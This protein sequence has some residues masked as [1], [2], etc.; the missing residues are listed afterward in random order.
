MASHR[1]TQ[2][3]L[4]LGVFCW[5]AG[6]ATLAG[7]AESASCTREYPQYSQKIQLADLTVLETQR[8]DID[9]DGEKD[10]L[11]LVPESPQRRGLG[12]SVGASVRRVIVGEQAE[13]A[14]VELARAPEYDTGHDA[15]SFRTGDLNGDGLLDIVFWRRA[16]FSSTNPKPQVFDVFLAAA[17]G[18]YS[19]GPSLE[20][21]FSSTF[22]TGDFNGDGRDELAV[23][24][25]E[26]DQLFI[27]E[28]GDDATWTSTPAASIGAMWSLV[29]ADIDGDGDDD[30]LSGIR[31]PR[32]ILAWVEG[33]PISPLMSERSQF[34]PFDLDGSPLTP[35]ELDRDRPGSEIVFVELRDRFV[36]WVGVLHALEYVPA[37]SRFGLVWSQTLPLRG[38]FFD[39]MPVDDDDLEDFVVSFPYASSWSPNSDSASFPPPRA[40]SGFLVLRNQARQR[41]SFEQQGTTAAR[42]IDVRDVDGDGLRDGIVLPRP[43]SRGLAVLRGEP[44]GGLAEPDRYGPWPLSELTIVARDDFNGDGIEDL[45]TLESGASKTRQ[46]RLGDGQGN[47]TLFDEIDEPAGRS[48]RS[49]FYEDFDLN[50]RIDVMHDIYDDVPGQVPRAVWV[51]YVRE[52]GTFEDYVIEVVPRAF[53]SITLADID[54]NSSPDLVGNVGSEH[55]T[56]FTGSRD[57][58]SAEET[59]FPNEG[60][61]RSDLIDFI[62]IDGDNREDL[63]VECEPV[64]GGGEE[65]LTWRRSRGDGTFGEP[66]TFFSWSGVERDSRPL[67]RADLDDDGI[68]DLVFQLSDGAETTIRTLRGIGGG[69]FRVIW[70]GVLERQVARRL[71]DFDGDGRLDL[72]DDAGMASF[73]SGDGTGQF[74]VS[75]GR[76]W[77]ADGTSAEEDLSEDGRVDFAGGFQLTLS[78]RQLVYD[79]MRPTALL[80]DAA[81]PL[82]LLN[83]TPIVDESHLPISVE[84]WRVTSS[85][86]D[87][88]DA[89]PRTS[90]LVELQS[91]NAIPNAAFRQTDRE[92]I[93]FYLDPDSRETFAVLLGADESSARVRFARIQAAG[94]VS[95]PPIA[96]I[97]LDASESYGA[98]PSDL[99]DAGLVPSSTRLVERA[100]FDDVDSLLEVSAQG[101]E[102]DVVVRGSA[103][104]A[105]GRETTDRVSF[106]RRRAELCESWLAGTV[107]CR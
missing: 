82:L 61:Q 70:R 97:G 15:V 6:L 47:F 29:S 59:F 32:N 64:A 35:V 40:D 51:S 8:A 53:W 77:Y 49:T 69:E 93:R 95:L 7:Q 36:P 104:D 96:E 24:L 54:G 28:L 19:A 84:T 105:A 10:L 12:G 94:G 37:S 14:S 56:V 83:V 99:G 43:S 89:S 21:T 92:E 91:L 16:R 13:L 79:P 60:C 106:K 71:A 65:Q 46:I 62:D 78:G 1:Y 102:Q 107:L 87:D 74:E 26:L 57:W 75:M 72:V 52:N 20:T 63:V 88:C 31:F 98:N 100:V 73:W 50:G 42:L 101:P 34:L 23:S 9:G 81:P 41:P 66:R 22:T 4:S 17:D 27:Y 103:R 38:R 30:V 55:W 80:T 3:A 58:T 44:G 45:M 25:D 39:V 76:S 48:F 67:L 90:Q 68:A 85:S 11:L 5:S 86:F 2:V 18:S 33:D